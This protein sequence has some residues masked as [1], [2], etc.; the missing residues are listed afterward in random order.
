M[1][2]SVSL[3]IGYAG[4][5]HT[6]VL[7]IGDSATEDQ[8]NEEVQEWANNYIEISWKRVV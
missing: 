3:G 5:N 8:I 7:D 6:D 4:A 1:Q 2:I